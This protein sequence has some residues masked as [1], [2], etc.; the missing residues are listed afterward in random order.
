MST[1]PTL[2]RELLD[3]E[4]VR[5]LQRSLAYE[6]A[7]SLLESHGIAV[8]PKGADDVREWI[9]LSGLTNEDCFGYI[10]EAFQYLDSRDLI[11][12]YQ[13]GGKTYIAVKDEA[14][15]LAL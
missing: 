9:D 8:E 11:E 14:E 1:F 7:A 13:R 10:R 4:R 15:G 5:D 12:R 6:L 2:T 3:R